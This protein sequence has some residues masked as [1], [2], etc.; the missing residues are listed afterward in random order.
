MTDETA[1]RVMDAERRYRK[2]AH[3]VQTAIAISLDHDDPAATP[4][5]LRVGV[6]LSKSDA[7]GLVTLLIA[8]GVFTIAEY[9]EA[10]AQAAEEEAFSH[11]SQ[12]KDKG[13]I[14]PKAKLG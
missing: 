3:A 7:K 1:K 5:H 12:L 14:P 2:A 13:W 11:E 4:K 6:D 8:K 9:V 10:I